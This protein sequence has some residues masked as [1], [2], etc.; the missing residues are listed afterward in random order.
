VNSDRRQ[1]GREKLIM[2]PGYVAPNFAIKSG[3][4]FVGALV[5]IF[6]GMLVLMTIYP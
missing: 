5:V 1:N 2:T 6:V 4:F 3:Y